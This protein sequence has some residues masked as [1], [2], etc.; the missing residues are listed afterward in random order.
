MWI[1]LARG[2]A[3][4]SVISASSSYRKADSVFPVPVGA[5]MSVSSPLAIAGQPPRC[6]ADGSPSVSVNHARTSGWNEASGCAEMTD[7]TGRS[8]H[9]DAEDRRGFAEGR[10]GHQKNSGVFAGNG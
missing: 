9:L 2:V 10:R 8:K 5:R 7:F 4:P 1:A 6:G 3:C